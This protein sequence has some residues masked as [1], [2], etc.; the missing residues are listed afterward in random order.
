MARPL[1][2][3]LEPVVDVSPVAL[4]LGAADAA[5]D[6]FVRCAVETNITGYMLDFESFGS[7]RP[8]G[9]KGGPADLAAV[10]VRW[11]KKL[12]AALHAADKTLA[13]CIS[14]YGVLGAYGAGY[15]DDAIDTVMT[16]ATYYNMA[17]Q[18]Q[19]ASI[20]PLPAWTDVTE[21]WAQWLV[22]PQTGPAR[23]AAARAPACAAALRAANCTTGAGDSCSACLETSYHELMAAKC[24]PWPCP[25]PHSSACFSAF[26]DGYC[27][28]GLPISPRALS[29]GIG[30]VTTQGCGCVNGSKGCCAH[31]ASPLT[32]K[33]FAAQ[34]MNYP[35]PCHTLGAT[36]N[37]FF[38]TEAALRRFVGWAAARID[39]VD[40]YR[41]GTSIDDS[42]TPRAG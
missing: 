24:S 20:G 21:L 13:V 40:I 32:D 27:A 2:L 3:T 26:A 22:V 14:D 30:Q 10:Y 36:G 31:I 17:N 33:A 39:N 25:G 28:L 16:M 37:C 42:C 23:P 29:A 9:F 19:H 15:G 8:P 5:V 4:A 7:A 6:A 35:P 1:G 18:S 11:L 41:G 12:G 38:W 34:P